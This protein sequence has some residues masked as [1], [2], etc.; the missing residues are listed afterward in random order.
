MLYAPEQSPGHMES[1]EGA[2]EATGGLVSRRQLVK[3]GLGM[4]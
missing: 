4:L 3:G 1:L 2:K